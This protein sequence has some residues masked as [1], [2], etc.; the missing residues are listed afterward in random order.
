MSRSW[1][2]VDIVFS[3]GSIFK[4]DYHRNERLVELKKI[5][6]KFDLKDVSPDMKKQVFH[7]LRGVFKKNGLDPITAVYLMAEM[8]ENLFKEGSAVRAAFEEARNNI[9]ALS[10]KKPV[11]S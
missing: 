4:E 6:I 8:S 9:E 10:D 5:D 2:V 1:N 3:N 7:D 11:I